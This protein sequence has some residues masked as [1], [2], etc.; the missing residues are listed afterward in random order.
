VVAVLHFVP[1]LDP[2]FPR[3]ITNK[4]LAIY[5]VLLLQITA[6]CCVASGAFISL[7]R[8]LRTTKGKGVH[9]WRSWLDTLVYG[10]RLWICSFI[11]GVGI[12]F[13]AQALM[14]YSSLPVL[15]M[16]PVSEYLTRLLLMLLTQCTGFHVHLRQLD[17]TYGAHF[18][19]K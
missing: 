1:A 6:Y 7:I 15:A 12:L 18:K 8:S 3:S 2:H 14:L 10:V 13:G 11:S 5:F 4:F 16:L 9:T 19:I 17:S